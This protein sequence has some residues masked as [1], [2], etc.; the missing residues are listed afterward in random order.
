MAE[1]VFLSFCLIALI[2]AGGAGEWQRRWWWS[3]ALSAA[4]VGATFTRM[5]G[6]LLVATILV[7][8]LLTQ[9][10][11]ARTTLPSLVAQMCGILAIIVVMT[12]LTWNDL[13]PSEY[14]SSRHDM[15]IFGPII[16]LVRQPETEEPS[17]TPPASLESAQAEPRPDIGF[18]VWD[19][20]QWGTR[21]HLFGHVRD[22]AISVGG[23]ERAQNF[24]D[25]L[26]MS[27]LPALSGVLIL[28][29]VAMGLAREGL[30]SRCSPFICFGIIYVLATSFLWR[31][32]GTRMFYPVQTQIQF[33]ML[34]GIQV[35]AALVAGRL[36][37]K[38]VAS[39]RL[40]AVACGV[41]ACAVTLVSASRAVIV[42]DPRDHIG[43]LAARSAWIKAHT[44]ASD[45]FMTEEPASDALY[46]E[47][48]TVPYPD[49]LSSHSADELYAY[50]VESNVTHVL[51]APSVVWQASYTPTYLSHTETL[52]ALLAELE[53]QQRLR[54]A[55][56]S[57]RDRVQVFRVEGQKGADL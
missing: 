23:G 57:E 25:R 1:P 52:A 5:V 43:D 40:A 4:L 33:G 39:W 3:P 17:T 36:H 9:G 13:V 10:R 41:V 54:V 32:D 55:Y 31:W 51:L 19:A 26:G 53:Q 16:A 11:R 35:L 18:R 15:L 12:P 42:Q 8:L 21:T 37:L 27:F 49:E 14:L 20:L 7:Y 29:V 22:I 48:R 2:L 46:S 56:T 50:I 45:V 38:P 24:A 30:R 6:V 28:A 47:R 34:V 44:A